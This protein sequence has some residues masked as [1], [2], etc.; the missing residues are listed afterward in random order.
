MYD[1]IT[2]VLAWALISLIPVIVLARY[3]AIPKRGKPATG[4]V[5]CISPKTGRIFN[6]DNKSKVTLEDA[7][8]EWN[9]T[10]D[11]WPDVPVP[12]AVTYL[13]EEIFLKAMR[14]NPAWRKKK[15]NRK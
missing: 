15:G 14:Q 12:I 1:I 9:K 11:E 2:T 10:D 3:L 13:G 7:L 8:R 5:F 6:W 4:G